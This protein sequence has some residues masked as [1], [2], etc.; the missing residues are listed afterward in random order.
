M[1][2]GAISSHHVKRCK[3]A[4]ADHA[5]ARLSRV[6]SNKKKLLLA[7]MLKLSENL[8]LNLTQVQ[9]I[10]HIKQASVFAV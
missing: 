9:Y 3:G 4:M 2:M 1:N 10:L 5:N 7:C 8:A 6:N